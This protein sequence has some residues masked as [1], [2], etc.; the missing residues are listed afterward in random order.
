VQPRPDRAYTR[1]QSLPGFAETRTRN[2]FACA[3]GC[4]TRGIGAWS[5]YTKSCA[6]GSQKRSRA[7]TEPTLGGK[8]CTD[9]CNDHSCPINCAYLRASVSGP[10]AAPRAPPARSA[11]AA[12]SCPAAPLP[13]LN[14]PRP[15][16]TEV[17][18]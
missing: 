7:Q 6:T 9:T 11:A 12:P 1:R 5:A 13:T 14:S 18:E 4:V 3:T 17:L 15:L 16:D 2:A 8:A 10:R